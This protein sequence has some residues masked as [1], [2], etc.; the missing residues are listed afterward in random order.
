MVPASSSM[1]WASRNHWILFGIAGAGLFHRQ[2]FVGLDRLLAAAS[3]EGTSRQFDQR[4]N[5][6]SAAAGVPAAVPRQDK[7][8]ATM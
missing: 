8:G 1:A 5:G 3:L 7:A 6:G 4:R 2:E